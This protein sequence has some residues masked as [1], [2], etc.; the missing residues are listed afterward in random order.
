M[1]MNYKTLTAGSILHSKIYNYIIEKTLGQGTFGITYLAKVQMLGSLGQLDSNV[2]VT[3]KEFFMKEI[4]GREGTNVTSTSSNKGSLFYEYKE[5]FAREAKNLSKLKHPNIVNVMDFFEANNTCYYVMEFLSGGDLDT[6]IERRDGL[7]EEETI[8]YI[9]Q[10][11]SALSFMHTN[12]MLHLDLKPKNVMLNNDGDAILIDFGLSK[13][14]DNNG[15]PE[16]STTVG[17]GTPGY[18]PLE[19]A[20]YQDGRGFPVTMDVY[21]LGATMYKML[22]NKRAPEASVIL[23]EGFPDNIIQSRGTSKQTSDIVKKAMSPL[24]KDRF[25]SVQELINDLSHNK[26]QEFTIVELP[27]SITTDV[28]SIEIY[29]DEG[30]IPNSHYYKFIIPQNNTMTFEIG[31]WG[32]KKESIKLENY[33]IFYELIDKFKDYRLTYTDIETGEENFTGGENTRITIKYINKEILLT[34]QYG[35]SQL[36]FGTLHGDI[37]SLISFLF[38]ITE[39]KELIELVHILEETGDDGYEI[40]SKGHDAFK[41]EK[42]ELAYKLFQKSAEKGDSHGQCML[43]Y[44]YETGFGTVKNQEKAISWYEKSSLQN[45]PTAIFNL[46]TVYKEGR[47]ITKDL[48]KA[49]ELYK[50]SAD[51]GDKD[52]LEHYNALCEHK[53]SAKDKNTSEDA[54]CLESFLFLLALGGHFLYPGLWCITFLLD[55]Y[56]YPNIWSVITAWIL[57]LLI[58]FL[59]FGTNYNKKWLL[60]IILWTL[61]ILETSIIYYFNYIV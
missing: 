36:S 59:Y 13:Q 21:A 47:G 56:S 60:N 37:D 45:N 24:K 10:I 52:A 15:E 1:E 2:H 50:K 43:G 55:K 40:Y 18:A 48:E 53:D 29:H 9:N 51:L 34:H 41:H 26:Q 33:S 42:K 19:Q 4:N 3:I 6:F 32:E 28:E 23:N 5:K 35:S 57:G 20:N 38:E 27:L 14:Y 31:L 7:S 58:T 17:R 22:T 30:S 49:I 11:G 39:I 46:A 44:C 25:Q 54:G 16:S 61:L 8:R 12:K